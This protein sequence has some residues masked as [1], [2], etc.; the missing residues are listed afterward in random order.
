M[1]VK[2]IV[3]D[4][5]CVGTFK[6]NA[7]SIKHGYDTIQ[8]LW[9]YICLCM[10]PLFLFNQT[11]CDVYRIGRMKPF[12]SFWFICLYIS[13][14]MF[15]QIQNQ[16]DVSRI[17]HMKPLESYRHICVCVRSHVC[18]Y[19][20]TCCDVS[21]LLV[22]IWYTSYICVRFRLDSYSFSTSWTEC[23]VFHV[24]IITLYNL[25]VLYMLLVSFAYPSLMRCLQYLAYNTIHIL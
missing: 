20:Q 8:I 9:M 11:H 16:C 23:D 3:Y 5:I 24:C 22:I 18:L 6:F 21:H 19:I 14:L 12:T 10:I 25:C 7:M 17:G 4:S 2:V 15:L 1:N 13:F